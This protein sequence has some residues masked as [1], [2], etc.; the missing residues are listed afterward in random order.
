MPRTPVNDQVLLK[1]DKESKVSEGGLHVVASEGKRTDS[2]AVVG[3]VVALPEQLYLV[4]GAIKYT[5]RFGREQRIRLKVG[6]TV[7][8]GKYENVRASDPEFVYI[9]LDDILG[10]M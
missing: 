1:L 2:V 6:D 7:E 9:R 8:V 4:D 10:K 3:T 5:D